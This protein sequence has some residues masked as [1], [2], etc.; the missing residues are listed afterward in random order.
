MSPQHVGIIAF[1]APSAAKHIPLGSTPNG[2][3]FIYSYSSAKDVSSY[4]GWFA[5]VQQPQIVFRKWFGGLWSFRNYSMNGRIWLTRWVSGNC[6]LLG[7]AKLDSLLPPGWVTS[8]Q[9]SSSAIIFS[10]LISRLQ[11]VYWLITRCYAGWLINGFSLYDMIGCHKHNC[12][13]SEMARL[14]L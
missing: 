6:Y 10:I 4:S 8:L 11:Y 1:K 3:Q 13:G 12:T 9:C 2:Q 14:R 5:W 7:C